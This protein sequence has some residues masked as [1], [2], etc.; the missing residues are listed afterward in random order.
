MRPYSFAIA[1]GH[2]MKILF[3][4]LLLLSL[5]GCQ[6]L[7][8]ESVRTSTE[9]DIVMPES[10]PEL[11]AE[12]EQEAELILA[13][14]GVSML[15]WLQ[16]KDWVLNSSILQREALPLH[17]D[18]QVA[19]IQSSLAQLHPDNNYLT[20]FRAQMQLAE[21]LMVAPPELTTLFSWELAFNQKLLEAESAVSALTRINAELQQELEQNQA[22]NR[23]LE[24]QIEALTQIEARLNQ[25]ENGEPHE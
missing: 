11:I 22:R 21:R 19:A 6:L 4:L 2:R 17:D 18:E 15:A 23:E 24:Q 20:R 1:R 14:D 7:Q 5:A 16:F 13:D 12:P 3:N 8:T 9:D 25:P 10:S